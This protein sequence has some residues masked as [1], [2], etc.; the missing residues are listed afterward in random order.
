[1]SCIRGNTVEIHLEFNSD[2]PEQRRAA[3]K[4]PRT[5]VYDRYHHGSIEAFYLKGIVHQT[6]RK[7]VDEGDK[8]E[9]HPQKGN[10][11]F[12]RNTARVPLM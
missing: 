8:F 6:A 3:A 9:C 5:A 2:L 1:M 10:R 7:R 12:A 4:S 11:P